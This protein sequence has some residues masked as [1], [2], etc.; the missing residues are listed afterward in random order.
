MAQQF[1]FDVYDW[2]PRQFHKVDLTPTNLEAGDG[3]CAA[4]LW[5]EIANTSLS[6]VIGRTEDYTDQ[7]EQPVHNVSRIFLNKR[8]STCTTMDEMPQYTIEFINTFVHFSPK[9]RYARQRSTSAPAEIHRLDGSNLVDDAEGVT[10]IAIHARGTSVESHLDHHESVCQNPPEL[11]QAL[12]SGTPVD[13]VVP[14]TLLTDKRRKKKRNKCERRKKITTVVSQDIVLSKHI[15]DALA[16]GMR[17]AREERWICLLQKLFRLIQKTERAFVEATLH[18]LKEEKA[19]MIE[20]YSLPLYV[21]FSLMDAV[22]MGEEL[23]EEMMKLRVLR[24]LDERM[25]IWMSP[26]LSQRPE[27]KPLLCAATFFDK[28]FRDDMFAIKDK[29]NKDKSKAQPMACAFDQDLTLD[30]LKGLLE[31]WWNVPAKTMHLVFRRQEIS[32]GKLLDH[33]V[34]PGSYIEVIYNLKTKRPLT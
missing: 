34:G 1:P 6:G 5:S 18:A 30:A 9:E 33:G 2:R 28:M 10:Q 24:P 22:S 25:T 20:M 11:M 14:V 26:Q 15:D 12:C 23:V 7:R 27:V 4:K 3:Q 32:G 16:E 8:N 13:S 21:F 29:S 19:N 31:I 17:M